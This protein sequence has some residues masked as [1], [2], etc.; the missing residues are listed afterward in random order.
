MRATEPTFTFKRYSPSLQMLPSSCAVVELS[1]LPTDNHPDAAEYGLPVVDVR[2]K[3]AEMVEDALRRVKTD[4]Y[5]G[6]HPGLM[7]AVLGP[8]Q[9]EARR[10][11]IFDQNFWQAVCFTNPVYKQQPH[12]CYLLH[13]IIH[14][15]LQGSGDSLE[16]PPLGS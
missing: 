2:Q 6:G 14:P 1:G 7:I 3:V 10:A 12:Y 5:E 4:L 8:L 16:K 11:L 15:S 13:K 9:E